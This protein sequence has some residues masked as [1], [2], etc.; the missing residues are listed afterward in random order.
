MMQVMFFK[1]IRPPKAAL[2][3]APQDDG[4]D[5]GVQPGDVADDKPAHEHLRELA[6]VLEQRQAAGQGDG[7]APG[8]DADAGGAPGGEPDGDEG[9][10]D[11][12]GDGDGQGGEFGPDSVNAG[13][14]VAFTAGDFQGA[15]KVSAV[16]DDGCTVTDKSGRAHRVHWNEITGNHPAAAPGADDAAPGAGAPQPAAK[17]AA[18]KSPK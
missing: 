14:Y 3:A 4:N 12:D 17:P 11:V 18:S 15:G 8:D 13:N 16:G 5:P 1:A 9:G 7:G 10:E 6:D 2:K